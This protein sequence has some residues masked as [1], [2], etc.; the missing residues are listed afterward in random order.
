MLR[1]IM[2]STV[3]V[4][5]VNSLGWKPAQEERSGCTLELSRILDVLLRDIALR[6]T[7]FSR[8]GVLCEGRV[9]QV[10]GGPKTFDDQS[11]AAAPVHTYCDGRALEASEGQAHTG[12]KT[13]RSLRTVS[14]Q[15]PCSK[16]QLQRLTRGNLPL[17]VKVSHEVNCL[18]LSSEGGHVR[19]CGFKRDF[20]GNGV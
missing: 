6:D 8:F 2:S 15:I 12:P 3:D 20:T 5:L 9:I 4:R 17:P 18:T 11:P 10:Q 16:L 1:E 7:V 14:G 13:F 19:V